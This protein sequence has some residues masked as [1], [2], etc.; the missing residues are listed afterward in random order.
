MPPRK[1]TIFGDDSDAEFKPPRSRKSE[2]AQPRATRAGSKQSLPQLPK[3]IKSNEAHIQDLKNYTEKL[4][5]AT[6]DTSLNHWSA[7]IDA[8]SNHNL[9][10][11]LPERPH[12]IPVSNYALDSPFY[13]YTAAGT[14]YTMGNTDPTKPAEASSSLGSPFDTPNAAGTPGGR[15]RKMANPGL[16][17]L[18]PSKKGHR[19]EQSAATIE[20]GLPSPQ[21]QDPASS[22][23]SSTGFGSMLN[24]FPLTPV[25]GQPG[26]P[27]ALEY[28][29][30]MP[31]QTVKAN[32]ADLFRD[33]TTGIVD[34]DDTDL[35]AADGNNLDPAKA[36][37]SNK[38]PIAFSVPQTIWCA[39]EEHYTA[40]PPRDNAEATYQMGVQY[41]IGLG[42]SCYK[43][44]LMD[45]LVTRGTLFG[46]RVRPD[47]GRTLGDVKQDIEARDYFDR[48]M[49][50]QGH[51]VYDNWNKRIKEKVGDMS[52][53]EL[54]L[55]YGGPAQ[56]AHYYNPRASTA[57]GNTGSGGLSQRPQGVYAAYGTNSPLTGIGA[58]DF[59]AGPS[60]VP[61]LPAGP[62]AAVVA[63]YDAKYHDMGHRKVGAR[64]GGS[65]NALATYDSGDDGILEFTQEEWERAYAGFGL[66]EKTIKKNAADMV[67][68]QIAVKGDRFV[69]KKGNSYQQGINPQILSR[70]GSTVSTGST[71]SFDARGGGMATTTPAAGTLDRTAA[72][73]TGERRD[74]S[75]NAGLQPVLSE[76]EK[77]AAVITTTRAR[78]SGTAKR[79]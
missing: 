11:V 15:K 49:A 13:N 25:G 57:A 1:A 3:T 55:R 5:N 24:Q 71:G 41:G 6:L 59:G 2:P 77:G 46:R 73:A 37:A 56:N 54:A 72:T 40:V 52:I 8:G 43:K 74:S 28:Q 32:N 16:E 33:F 18:P 78:G 21:L 36:P 44:G 19:G 69:Q 65:A 58:P 30:P 34:S 48:T 70:T 31:K 35:P 17:I 47:K 22:F 7:E 29:Q 61:K 68:H 53:E 67:K 4:I 38:A 62:A 20:H 79:D 27:K 64:G 51:L 39:L 75:T 76:N 23:S 60:R 42:I 45:E 14:S 26:M 12:H 63:D 50:G 10:P 66:D 9:E